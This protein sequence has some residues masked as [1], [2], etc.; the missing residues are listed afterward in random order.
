MGDNTGPLV[1]NHNWRALG[2]AK[3]PT[4]MRSNIWRG[5]NDNLGEIMDDNSGAVVNDNRELI[6][7]YNS[8]HFAGKMNYRA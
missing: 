3:S 6:V 5:V 7:T 4:N 8:V 1:Y 2:N